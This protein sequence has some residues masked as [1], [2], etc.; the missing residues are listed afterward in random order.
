[1]AEVARGRARVNVSGA[2]ARGD[3]LRVL[4]DLGQAAES[5]LEVDR[6]AGEEGSWLERTRVALAERPGD[7]IA[8]AQKDS[9]IA[10]VD[11]V[12]DP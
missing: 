11:A 3:G 5:G 8:N 2:A 6:T 4:L 1:M 12:G 7:V 9:A 10:E